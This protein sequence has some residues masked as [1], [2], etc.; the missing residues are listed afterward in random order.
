MPY[1]AA[2]AVFLIAWVAYWGFTN[3]GSDQRDRSRYP[4][5][6]ERVDDLT[7]LAVIRSLDPEQ[8]DQQ[9]LSSA[10]SFEDPAV[11]GDLAGLL[12]ALGQE[13]AAAQGGR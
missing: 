8:S 12:R 10:S 7:A 11:S 3:S 6:A 1:F 2:A 13:A 9:A 5:E 4:S